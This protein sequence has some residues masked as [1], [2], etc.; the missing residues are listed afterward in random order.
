MSSEES[1]K[2]SPKIPSQD[3]RFENPRPEE[4][5][6]EM[7]KA[8][9][10]AEDINYEDMAGGCRSSLKN[11]LVKAQILGMQRQRGGQRSNAS[12]SLLYC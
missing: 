7:M 11:N 8:I 6:A 9:M 12:P 10:D 4:D 3:S 5:I 2:T 1:N